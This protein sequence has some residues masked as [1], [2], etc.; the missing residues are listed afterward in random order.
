MKSLRLAM[1]LTLSVFIVSCADGQWNKTVRGNGNVVKK[2]RPASYFDGV[3][4]SSGID[5]YITQGD[6]ESITVEADENL[7]EY[8][9]TEIKDGK[10]NVYHDNIN[11]REAERERVYVTM[12][13]VK[14]IKTTSAGDIIGET[15]LKS[16]KMV[17][18]ASSA[19][20]IKVE[21]YAKAI[22]VN[23]SS[24]G[25]IELSGEAE[26]MSADLSSAGDLDAGEFKVKE[27]NVSVSSAG[28]ATVFVTEKL[29]ARSSSAGNITYKGSPKA[30]D[31]HSSSAGGIHGK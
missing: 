1:I 17:I 27:A 12:K 28:D 15:P 18:G 4:A 7:H 6:K 22:E 26:T 23:I 25:D 19:G 5:V 8:I 13:D 21:V 2:E 14:S 31:A 24:A 20:D 10:L 9:I 29:V 30:V 16:D 3:K 11:V